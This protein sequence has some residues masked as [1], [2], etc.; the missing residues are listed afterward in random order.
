MFGWNFRENNLNINLPSKLFGI[1]GLVASASGI[2]Y[3]LNTGLYGAQSVPPNFSHQVSFSRHQLS[4]V[5]L[6]SFSARL[7]F[8]WH[9]SFFFS[10]RL[11]FSALL[12]FFSARLFVSARLFFIGTTLFF[13]HAFFLARPGQVT[14]DQYSDTWSSRNSSNKMVES[15]TDV[16]TME[17]VGNLSTESVFLIIIT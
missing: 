8:F 15:V 17:E 6:F 11:F 3:L 5:R 2:R 1:F 16:Y 9:D 13:R 14:A 4:L 7:F 10:A 12:F